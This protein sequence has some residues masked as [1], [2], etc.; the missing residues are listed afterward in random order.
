MDSYLYF[1]E[2]K[3]EICES[4]V[5]NGYVDF[6]T[7]LMSWKKLLQKVLDLLQWCFD[8]LKENKRPQIKRKCGLFPA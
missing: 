6:S 2:Q 5:Y 3:T 7:Y 4:V 1:L 8:V